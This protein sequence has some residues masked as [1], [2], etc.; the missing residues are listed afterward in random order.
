MD[1]FMSNG[2]AALLRSGATHA[3]AANVDH[4]LLTN[5]LRSSFALE[6]LR[7]LIAKNAEV[8]NNETGLMETTLQ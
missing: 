8:L 5:V 6:E 3:K 4:R 1:G 7:E 2:N